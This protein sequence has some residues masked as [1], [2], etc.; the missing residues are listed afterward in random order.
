MSPPIKQNKAKQKQTNRKTNG[1]ENPQISSHP[2]SVL[3]F[4]SSLN[5]DDGIKR[6]MLSLPAGQELKGFA[7]RASTWTRGQKAW[8][9]QIL[10]QPRFPYLQSGKH[11][12]ILPFSW[13]WCEVHLRSWMDSAF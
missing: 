7:E 11:I 3:W 2:C 12:P 10:P 1:S 13:G 8:A 4:L 5:Y 9:I 6:W